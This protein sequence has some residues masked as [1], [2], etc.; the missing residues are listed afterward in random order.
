LI[1]TS[2]TRSWCCCCCSLNRSDSYSWS[3][4]YKYF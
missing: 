1:W 3:S 2:W 4:S